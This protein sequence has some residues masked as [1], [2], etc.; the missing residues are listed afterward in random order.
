MAGTG[1]A[2]RGDCRGQHRQRHA[3]LDLA[4]PIRIPISPTLPNVFN[5]VTWIEGDFVWHDL[6][7]MGTEGGAMLYGLSVS[8]EAR[9]GQPWRLESVGERNGA[10]HTRLDMP[11]G[12]WNALTAITCTPGLP[13]GDA[14]ADQ[15]GLTHIGRVFTLSADAPPQLALTLTLTYNDDDLGVVPEATLGLYRW[16]TAEQRWAPEADSDLDTDA[17][18][19][20]AR[21]SD[22]GTFALIG[23]PYRAHVPIVNGESR[24]LDRPLVCHNL[25]ANG[26]FESGPP[27]IPWQ[28]SA[29]PNDPLIYQSARRSGAWGAW[30][31]ARVNYTDTLWQRIDLP[32][33]ATTATLTLWWRMSTN[34]TT[35]RTVYDVARFGL[36]NEAGAWVSPPMTVTN[37]SARNT[38]TAASTVIDVS[39]QA[40]RRVQLT[41]TSSNDYSKTTSWFVDDVALHVCAPQD[42]W[43]RPAAQGN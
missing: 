5:R 23:A 22:L 29:A 26:G 31:G 38:W 33:E 37:L 20:V 34:E 42:A 14:G 4:A 13:F 32:R 24:L 39:A 36:R 41:L 9:P 27:G 1:C 28:I 30:L 12:A 3:L 15:P 8:T 16:D 10:A 40:G 7:Q 19:L 11:I 35:T 6:A 43:S 17:N 18:R 21:I 2:W 25:A